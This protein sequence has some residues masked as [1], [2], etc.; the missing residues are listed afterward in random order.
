[1]YCVVK[2]RENRQLCSI[3]QSVQC[4][5]LTKR[6]FVQKEGQKPEKLFTAR[7]VDFLLYKDTLVLNNLKREDFFY[8]FIALLSPQ[9]Y[10]GEGRNFLLQCVL[11]HELKSFFYFSN[12]KPELH[13]WYFALMPDYLHSLLSTLFVKV[14]RKDTSNHVL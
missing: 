2:V 4:Q 8:F 7:S 6:P 13:C 3:K 14:W 10:R 9:L 5:Q 12:I 1:M 11:F